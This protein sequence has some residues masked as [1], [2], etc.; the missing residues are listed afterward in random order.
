MS[1]F[2]NNLKLLRQKSKLKQAEIGEI[3]GISASNWSNYEVGKAEPDLETIVKIAD[4]LKVSV[5]GLLRSDLSLIAGNLI[6]GNLILS[7]PESKTIEKGNVKG[8]LTGNLKVFSEP[9]LVYS[10]MPKVVTVDSLGRDNVVLVPIKARAGYLAGY[11]DAEYLA[12]LPSFILPNM[13]AGTF[14]CFEADGVSMQPVIK[15]RDWVVSKFVENLAEIKDN[16]V[17]TVVTFSEG[18]ITK[19]FLNRIKTDGQLIGKSDNLSYQRERGMVAID[20]ADVKEV[21]MA[22]RNITAQLGE[23]SELYDRVNELESRLA[24]M[25]KRLGK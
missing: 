13:P 9:E 4:V 8:N 1:H 3:A 25:E 18:I 21:W 24:L 5:D 23:P 7:K 17:Y 20:A 11:G 16:W 14:R 6:D 10:R 22:Y 2:A 19:R 15:H 12:S